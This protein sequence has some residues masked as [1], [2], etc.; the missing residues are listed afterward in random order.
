MTPKRPVELVYVPRVWP[1]FAVSSAVALILWPF[2]RAIGHP[3]AFLIFA[4]GVFCSGIITFALSSRRR[5]GLIPLAVPSPDLR[6]LLLRAGLGLCWG[7]VLL[8]LLVLG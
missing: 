6:N 4:A 2:A 1:A 7:A 5:V 3:K 8:V